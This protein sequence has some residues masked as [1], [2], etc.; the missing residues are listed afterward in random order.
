MPSAYHVIAF[1]NEQGNK[2]LKSAFGFKSG[3][4]YPK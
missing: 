1:Q 2:G 4:R 3:T